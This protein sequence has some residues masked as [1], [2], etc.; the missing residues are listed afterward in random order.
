MLYFSAALRRG[1]VNMVEAM[2]TCLERP[3]MPN[4][5]NIGRLEQ[6]RHVERLP[7]SATQFIIAIDYT[8]AIHH[9]WNAVWAAVLSGTAEMVNRWRWLQQNPAAINTR[10]DRVLMNASMCHWR[11]LKP[12]TNDSQFGYLRHR[13]CIQRTEQ[14][15]TRPEEPGAVGVGGSG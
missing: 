2:L 3:E 1:Y 12:C 15:L 5:E 14:D 9:A 4:E 7:S 8:P 11:H 13:M 6:G 10:E